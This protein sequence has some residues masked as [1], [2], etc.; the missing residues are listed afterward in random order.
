VAPT[1]SG[2]SLR[3]E[4]SFIAIILFDTLIFVLSLAKMGRM[5]I[6]KRL[7]HSESSI[8]NILLRDGSILYTVIT[9]SNACNFITFMVA[10]RGNIFLNVFRFDT[11]LFVVSSGTNSELT[12]A[13]SV[14]L[15]SRMIFNLRE[16]GTEIYEG[17][18]E[19]RSR[20]EGTMKGMQFRIP[21]TIRDDSA[22]MQEVLRGH[23]SSEAVAPAHEAGSA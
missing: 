12:H 2:S 15:V 21:T 22:E 9:F 13:L 17:T 18:E 10:T 1:V 19:W 7:F 14:I 8:M 20:V 3:Y 4:M 11:A 16:A 6:A 5:Y 23:F